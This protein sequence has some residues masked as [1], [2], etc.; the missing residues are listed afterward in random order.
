MAPPE[1]RTDRLLLRKPNEGDVGAIFERYA[2]D[3]SVCR[4]L[5]WPVHKSVNDTRAFLE[6]SE[7]EWQGWPAGP[8]LIFSLLNGSLIGS[9]GLK[10]ETPRRAS[11]GYVIAKDSWGNGFATEALTAMKVTAAEAGVHRLFAWCH[12][13]HLRSRRVLEKCGFELEGLLRRYGEFPNLSPGIAMDVVSYSW[14]PE[15]E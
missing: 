8:Y 14:L 5:A 11:T 13:D 9:T 6:F 10:F 15:L 4:Y 3:D 2:S 12:P 7:S 1:I